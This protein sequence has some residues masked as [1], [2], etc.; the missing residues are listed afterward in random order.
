MIHRAILGSLER[1]IGI[2]I[3]DNEGKL[4][5]WLSPVQFSV[6]NITDRQSDY[7]LNVQ[8]VLRKSGYRGEVDLRNEKIG[9]K[10]REATLRRVPYLIVVGDSEMSLNNVS[11]RR[12]SGEDLGIMEIGQL[13]EL[14]ADE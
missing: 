5:F 9:Y 13:I 4:P 1:F 8:K 10:I 11:V 7:A 6:M 14:V 3:E 12:R 2:L